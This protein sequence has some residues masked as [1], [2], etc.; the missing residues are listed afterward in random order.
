MLTNGNSKLKEEFQGASWC[1]QLATFFFVSISV[2]RLTKTRPPYCLLAYQSMLASS[3]CFDEK[4]AMNSNDV[5]PKS[6]E[7]SSNS[8]L[9]REPKCEKEFIIRGSSC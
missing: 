6:A 9:L 8:H 5:W 7:C 4:M 1:C 3:S 2:S